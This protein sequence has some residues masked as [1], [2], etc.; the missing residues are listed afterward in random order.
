MQQSHSIELAKTQTVDGAVCG[1]R[2]IDVYDPHMSTIKSRI[3][4]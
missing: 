4:S 1:N 3:P 2:M